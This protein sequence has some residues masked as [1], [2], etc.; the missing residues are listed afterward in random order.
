MVSIKDVAKHAGVAISTV[1]KVLN[2]YPNVS[3]ETKKK[4][5][6]AIEELGFIPNTIAAALSSKK[7]GRVALLMN[8]VTKTQ[9]IDE[10]DM[11]YLAGALHQAKECSLDVITVFFSMIQDK[12]L[13]EIIAY[14]KSQNISGIIIY[15]MSKDD[16]VLHQLVQAQEFKIVL[17]DAPM[18][19]DS[20][21]TVWIDQAKAQ[22]DV[23]KRVIKENNCK[24]IL[25]IAGK[26]NGYVTE[27]RLQ[28]MKKLAKDLKL[29]LTVMDGEFSELAARNITFKHAIDTEWY[30]RLT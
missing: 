30:V 28:G 23:A 8:L 4:V 10:I 15:G 3:E 26:R 14:F 24:R 19:N 1:S 21:S 7:A 17:I 9:A 29:K 18:V 2:H 22:Y 5:N 6:D 13:E 16:T 27:A 20:T 25:Y 12:S 11:Q